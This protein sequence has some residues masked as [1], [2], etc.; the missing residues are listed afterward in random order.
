[1]ILDTTHMPDDKVALINARLGEGYS[2]WDRVKMG[3]T[4]SH[5]MVIEEYSPGFENILTRNNSTDFCSIELRPKGIMVHI[6]KRLNCYSWLVPY[7]RLSIYKSRTYSLHAEGQFLK[8]RMDKNY[9][10]NKKLLRQ[11]AEN[12]AKLSSPI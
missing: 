4:G 1:M 6:H 2:L 8:L 12:K 3:G 10:M 5:R 9:E 7:F 11:I